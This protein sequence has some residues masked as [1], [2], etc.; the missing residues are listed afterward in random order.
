MQCVPSSKSHDICQSL[1]S[2]TPHLWRLAMSNPTGP[3]AALSAL[4]PATTAEGLIK[5][6]AFVASTAGEF[7]EQ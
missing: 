3:S 5:T 6:W 2:T 1:L 7:G 4:R